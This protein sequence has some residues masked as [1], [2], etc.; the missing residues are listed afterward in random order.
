MGRFQPRACALAVASAFCAGSVIAAP[1]VSWTEPNAGATLSGQI[2]I[3]DCKVNGTRIDRVRFHLVNSSGTSTFL[4][5]DGNSGYNCYFDSTKFPDGSYTLRAVAYDNK[6]ATATANRSVTLKN[7][8]TSGGTATPAPTPSYAYSGTPYTGTPIALPKVWEA[9]DF[10]KGGNSV[11]YKDL[12]SGNAGGQYRTGDSVD[13]IASNDP[14]GGGYVVNN[15]QTGEWLAYTVNVPADGLYDISIRAANNYSTSAAFRVLVD[16]VDVTGK[17]AVPMTGSWSSYQWVGKQGVSLKA[18]KRIVML[19]AD[20]QY[21]NVNQVSV[22]SQAPTA[23]L[24]KAPA[25]SFKQPTSG[26]TLAGQINGTTGYEEATD[27]VR[28][29]RVEFSMGGKPLNVPTAA[30]WQCAIDTTAFQN[31]TYTLQAKAFDDAGMKPE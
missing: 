16:G 25:V 3:A 7:G 19:V 14:A 26:A 21:F 11:A 6:D 8:T 27:D 22:L 29:Q 23:P 13:I 20:T 9:E 12:T 1:T 18:G 31:G 5:E 24:N 2:N 28:V 4:M 15:F 17:V 30:P 10:D